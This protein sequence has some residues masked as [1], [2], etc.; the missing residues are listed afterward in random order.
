LDFIYLPDVALLKA[1]CFKLITRDFGI[2]KIQQHT[3]L[4]TSDR[5]NSLF[6]G[7]KFKLKKASGTM[8]PLLKNRALKRPILFAVIFQ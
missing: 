4:Y 7:R 1:G 8:A 5:L 6:P 3:H 2:H